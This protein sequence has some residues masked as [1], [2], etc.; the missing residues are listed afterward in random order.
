M[1]SFLM[2]VPLVER[3]PA[4]VWVRRLTVV[5]MSGPCACTLSKPTQKKKGRHIY[6]YIYVY[7]Y[8][9]IDTFTVY[10]QTYTYIPMK[11]LCEILG[12]NSCLVV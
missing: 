6:I 4:E 8:I 12:F 9:H 5:L 7:I 1:Q 2:P 10:M 11:K 3:S